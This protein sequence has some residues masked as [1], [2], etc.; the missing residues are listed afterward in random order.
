MQRTEVYGTAKPLYLMGVGAGRITHLTLGNDETLC[1]RT[2][3]IVYLDT[4]RGDDF[5]A[6]CHKIAERM[7]KVEA[8]PVD[9]AEAEWDAI[10]YT[11]EGGFNLDACEECMGAAMGNADDT[12]V[13]ENFSDRSARWYRV[14]VDTYT[15]AHA[16][17]LHALAEAEHEV[18]TPV[19]GTHVSAIESAPH[20]ND[21]DKG[22]GTMAKTKFTAT[23]EGI[24]FE[25]TSATRVYTHVVIV[26]TAE[27]DLAD[28]RW[29]MSP[30]AAAKPLP[31]GWESYRV[32]TVEVAPADPKAPRKVSESP[33]ETKNMK[34]GDVRGDVR[35][36]S[37]TGSTGTLHAIK[38]TVD[39]KNVSYC[40]MRAKS[41]LRSFGPAAEQ[42][43]K[44]D[45]CAQCSKVVPTGDVEAETVMV[46]VPG[47]NRSVPSTTYTPVT[48]DDNN[49]ENMTDNNATQD[50]QDVEPTQPDADDVDALM[51]DVHATL[52]QIKA[53]DPKSEGAVSAAVALSTEA[54]GKIRQLPVAKRSSLRTQV[55]AAV[56]AVRN[57][58]KIEDA[59]G[60]TVAKVEAAP[61]EAYSEAVKSLIDH[62]AQRMREGVQAGMALTNA[63]EEVARVL[64]TIRQN[65]VDPETKLP[66]LTF[67]RKATRDAASEVYAKALEGVA[68]DDVEYRNAHASLRKAAQNKSADV[69]VE[70]LRGY[71]R[72]RDEDMTLLGEMFP[73]AVK[74]LEADADLTAEE[75]I[76]GLYAAHS[77]E[78]PKYG[79][80]EL[81]RIDRR[82]KALEAKSKELD[83]L[84]DADDAP[85]D[86]VE[87]LEGA[88]K[89]LKAEIPAEVLEERDGKV[90]PT[91]ADRAKEALTKLVKGVEL[92]GKRAAKVT[93]KAAKNKLKAQ[94][95]DAV[96]ALVAQFDLDLS[97]L[98]EDTE[99]DGDDAQ[100]DDN[101][102]E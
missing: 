53:I 85:A 52:D 7:D 31:N 29:S 72:T 77:I 48:G 25:R 50:A 45:L 9:T 96:R 84:K 26:R 8:E 78:L 87:E 55:S 62:A 6:R 80:T 21:N 57:A 75:A 95:Y 93:G 58:A 14:A 76:R 56:A 27:G 46:E 71:D 63:G 43:P 66:D 44:L 65:M 90:E 12:S 49:G 54:E 79:R 81:A 40:K 23:F 22:T 102:A 91:D 59:P 10:R 73:D 94:A 36:G 30:E 97:A 11:A 32:A 61:V 99:E 19:E 2:A 92:A 64:L 5:C 74:A 15:A 24:R 69:L 68:D 88:I 67:K 16:Q 33:K 70:W 98:V 4:V 37:V 1:G 13:E 100:A 51:S 34:I 47:L 38:E 82:V 42:N 17:H 83:A 20:H 28:A 35:I 41:P 86:K 60:S 89:E 39:G 18:G 101:A 3:N